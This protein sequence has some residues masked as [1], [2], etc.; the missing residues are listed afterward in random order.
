[1]PKRKNTNINSSEAAALLQQQDS[2]FDSHRFYSGSIKSTQSQISNDDKACV[3]EQLLSV[4]PTVSDWAIQELVKDELAAQRLHSLPLWRRALERLPALLVTLVIELVVAFVIAK[5]AESNIFRRYPLLISFQPVI[6][7]I[8]GNI[9]LQASS[10]LIR[11][12]QAGLQKNRKNMWFG[13]QKEV[14][15]SSMLAISMGM[16]LFLTSMIWYSP[17]VNERSHTWHGA[18]IFGIAIGIGQ[19]ASSILAALSGSLAP[20]LFAKL[21][22]DP[23]SLAGPMETAVQDIL[24]SSVL[25]AFSVWILSTFGDVGTVCPG[26]SLYG[27]VDTCQLTPLNETVTYNET[28]LQQCLSYAV[29]GEC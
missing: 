9:G 28:C 18:V 11:E 17:G 24:G 22:G 21:F 29:S 19:L 6:S 26:G 23:T 16:V 13:M 1:M 5:Y 4:D 8:S 20:L 15:V 14:V 27:C 3:R 2:D 7:A 25:L 10:I 12:L